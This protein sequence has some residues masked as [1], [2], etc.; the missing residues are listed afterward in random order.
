M[1]GSV[2]RSAAWAVA[3]R[4]PAASVSLRSLDATVFSRACTF[5]LR[6]PAWDF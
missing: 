1:R 5:R 3:W 6:A 2:L 4:V